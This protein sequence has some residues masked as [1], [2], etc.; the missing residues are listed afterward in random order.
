M[1]FS[2]LSASLK[3]AVARTKAVHRV[4]DRESQQRRF[5]AVGR[6]ERKNLRRTQTT[7]RI[8][9]FEAQGL[10]ATSAD[11]DYIGFTNRHLRGLSESLTLMRLKAWVINDR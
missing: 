1:P 8:L 9:T 4:E 11:T 10:H 3:S 7:R 5:E 2:L 6:A